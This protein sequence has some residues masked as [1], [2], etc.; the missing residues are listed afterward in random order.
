M[1]N[2]Q[3]ITTMIMNKKG[4]GARHWIVAIILIG[5]FSFLMITFAVQFMNQNMNPSLQND[6]NII[7][8]SVTLNNSLNGFSK[9]GQDFYNAFKQ[10]SKPDPLQIFLIIPGIISS[11]TSILY[12]P[13][14]T[15]KAILVLTM[16]EVPS[17]ALTILIS[18]VT[19]II[20][21]TMIFLIYKVIRTGES[22]R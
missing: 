16:G 19:G 20:F 4:L 15:I 6:N 18:V 12:L 8:A 9:S 17:P 1:A 13:F 21:I 7:N 10:N 2:K 3:K 5:L 11:V 22:E 14:D